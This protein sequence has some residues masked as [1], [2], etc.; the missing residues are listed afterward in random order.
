MF[1]QFVG[2]LKSK[3]RKKEA[4]TVE[5]NLAKMLIVSY[6]I[7]S[8]VL[9]YFASSNGKM[10]FNGFHIKKETVPKPNPNDLPELTFNRNQLDQHQVKDNFL[11]H[12]F[13]PNLN[14]FMFFIRFFCFFRLLLVY[15]FTNKIRSFIHLGLNF[16]SSNVLFYKPIY[17]RAS[18]SLSIQSNV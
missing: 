15:F 7:V 12:F 2:F 1:I 9:V 8:Y 17:T 18:Q 3:M 5:I 10:Q 16:Y 4:L 6:R 14:S 13:E 11:F